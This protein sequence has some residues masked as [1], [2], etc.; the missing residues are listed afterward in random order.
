M[1]TTLCIFKVMAVNLPIPY[2]HTSALFKVM[3]VILPILFL[4]PS[5]LLHSELLSS[6]KLLPLP[7]FP[8]HAIFRRLRLTLNESCLKPKYRKVT[9]TVPGFLKRTFHFHLVISLVFFS[10]HFDRKRVAT[11][12]KTHGYIH[13]DALVILWCTLQS[14]TRGFIHKDAWLHPQRRMATSTKMRW[15]F[16]GAHLIADP[17]LHPQRGT[18]PGSHFCRPRPHCVPAALLPKVCG[19]RLH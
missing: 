1:F 10:P 15:L 5:A 4:N 12:T 9:N 8:S 19:L 11:S 6:H 13:K 2:L 14:Q 3:A 7:L 18:L 16:F 17:R